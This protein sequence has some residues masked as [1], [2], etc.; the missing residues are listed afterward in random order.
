VPLANAKRGINVRGFSGI[1]LGSVHPGGMQVGLR[2]GGVD[3][4]SENHDIGV[5][6]ARLEGKAAVV[7]SFDPDA[8]MLGAEQEP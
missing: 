2:S 7:E 4:L 3:F 8:E 5:L 1:G 6:G